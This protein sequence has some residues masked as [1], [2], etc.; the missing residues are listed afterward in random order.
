VTFA[1]IVLA[2]SILSQVLRFFLSAGLYWRMA[3]QRG[4]GEAISKLL[5][6]AVLTGGFSV[7]VGCGGD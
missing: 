3:L 7:G 2:A 5:H 6:Y 4:T 1:A